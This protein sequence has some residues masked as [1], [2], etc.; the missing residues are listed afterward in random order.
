MHLQRLCAA[1]ALSAAVAA[2]SGADGTP[3]ATGAMGPAGPAG[4]AGPKG[5]NGEQGPTG[6]AGSKGDKGEAGPKGDTGDKGADGAAGPKGDPGTP[7]VD[8]GTIAGAVKDANKNA[9]SDVDIAT[10]PP[11]VSVKSDAQGAFT[12]P[13]TPIG[14]YSLLATKQGF[15]PFTLA[16]VNVAA[17]ATTNVSLALTVDASAPSDVTGLVKDATKAGAP[18]AGAKVSVQGQ[19]VSATTDAQGKFTLSGVAPGPVFLSVDSPDLSK[20]LPTETR[21][22]VFVPPASSVADVALT[23]S[24]RPTDAATF[25]GLD[26]GCSTCHKSHTTALKGSAHF[27]S[28]SL[29]QGRIINPVLTSG[30]RAG[31]HFWPEPGE[32]LDPNVKATSP[33]AN[34]NDKAAAVV[35]V[36]LCNLGKNGQN[37]YWMKFGTDAAQDAQG[38]AAC[39][40]KTDRVTNPIVRIMF[41]YGGEG[42]RDAAM[43]SHPNLGVFKQRFQAPLADI[44]SADGWNYTGAADKARDSVT[45]PVQIIQSGDTLKFSG[46]HGSET[47]DPHESWTQRSRAFSHFCAGCHNTGLKL[48]WDQIQFTYPDGQQANQAA[49][50]SYDYVDLNVTCEHCHGPGSDHVS[51]GG[52]KGVAIINPKYLT[53]EAE[54]Q[55]CGKCHAFD[56]GNNAKPAQDYGFEYPWNSDYAKKIGNGSFVPGV[57]ELGDFFDNWAEHADA[58]ETYWDPNKTGGVPRGFQHRQQFT[59]FEFSKHANNPYEKLTCGNCHDSHST[60]LGTGTAESAKGD[61]YKFANA[62]YKNDVLCL[63]CHAGFGP[64]AGVTK[65]DVAAVHVDAGGTATKNGAAVVASSAADLGASQGAIAGA[66]SQHMADKAGM[67]DAPYTPWDDKLPSGRCASCHMPKTAKSGGWTTGPDALGRESL[68]EGDEGSHVFDIVW[69]SQSSPT[70]DYG[71]AVVNGVTYKKMGHMPNSCGKCHTGSRV[72]TDLVP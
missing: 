48:D 15:A 50:K 22:A 68:V 51:S 30:P 24:S 46:Y 36:Y 34:P 8:Q 57:Y 1:I 62:T 35:K 17:G 54:R 11:T 3:G 60:Y 28:L 52:G 7:A 44:A 66:V 49:I 27:R 42:D 2:C 18:I 14:V 67:T 63:G 70:A 37:D 33:A 4:S 39:D 59:Q 16:N 41:V 5:A 6:P 55:A 72:A 31:K 56:A 40:Q 45:L 12:L 10:D 65:D 21:A 19:N 20:Y 69:P 71:T 25:V 47:S 32:T 61:Q 38:V 64:F 58:P 23:M 43:A 9:L 13:N 53:A 26:G 29:G